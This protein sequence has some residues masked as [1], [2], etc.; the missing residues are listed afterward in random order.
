MGMGTGWV[1]RGYTGYPPSAR[2]EGLR[3]RSGPRRALQGPGVGG[4]RAGRVTGGW[5]DPAPTLRARSVLRPSLVQDL[6][7][8]PLL[9]NIGEN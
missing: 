2:E 9:A 1:Y 5:T 8:V 4:L 3:Q 6:A 7:N